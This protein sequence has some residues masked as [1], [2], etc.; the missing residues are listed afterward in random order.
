MRFSVSVPVLSEQMTVTEPSVSTAGSL[1]MSTLRFSIRW[2][3]RASAIVTTA[4]RPSGTAA[5]AMLT[6]VRNIVV[7]SS[8][9]IRPT[10]K[11]TATSTSAIA[12][13]AWPSRSRRFCRG[14]ASRW[15][16]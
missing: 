11:M 12:A 6:A 2:A 16:V 5:T 4:G 7:R 9:R 1:R 8:P 14:V 3:P 15:T 10:A 13:S